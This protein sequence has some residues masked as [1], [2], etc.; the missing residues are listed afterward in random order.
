MIY[1]WLWK[2]NWLWNSVRDKNSENDLLT[3]W[4]PESVRGSLLF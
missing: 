2:N 3:G 1:S 4:I